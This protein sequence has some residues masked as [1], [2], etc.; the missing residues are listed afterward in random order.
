MNDGLGKDAEKKIF[1]WLDRPEEGYDMNRIPDQM[2]G[3]FGSKNICDF[4]LSYSSN[5]YYIESKATWEDSFKFSML[6]KYQYNNLLIKSKIQNV[7]GLVIALFASYKRAFVLDINEIDRLQKELDIHSL[8]IKKILGWKCEYSEIPTIP[9]R[10]R[11]LDY[12][13]GIE[14]LDKAIMIKEN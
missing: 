4:T 14:V 11:L 13:G 1:K 10:K 5:Y 3:L 12:S 8:N 9:S 2:S 6:T 7:Y